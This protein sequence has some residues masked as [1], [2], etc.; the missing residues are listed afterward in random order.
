VGYWERMRAP[1]R[2][3]ANRLG[4]RHIFMKKYRFVETVWGGL[5]TTDKAS[6]LDHYIFLGKKK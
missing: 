2:N 1:K 4:G 3:I 6:G 5:I